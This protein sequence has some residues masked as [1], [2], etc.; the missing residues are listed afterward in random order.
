[1]T[2]IPQWTE[3]LALP[4]PEWVKVNKTKHGDQVNGVFMPSLKVKSLDVGQT[5]YYHFTFDEPFGW[6]IFTINN[7]TGEFSIQ[8]DWGNW[9]Y[10]WGIS[11][12]GEEAQAHE[13]PLA[14]F[15]SDRT[16]AGYIVNKFSY[17]R[18]DYEEFDGEETQEAIKKDIIRNRRDGE[19][20]A[21]EARMYWDKLD[22]IDF[23]DVNGFFQDME[24]NFTQDYIF[25]L[26]QEYIVMR[27]TAHFNILQYKLLPFFFEYLKREVI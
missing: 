20:D 8:S 17:N 12:L 14:Y 11:N 27:Q 16:E 13:K 18:K 24:Y 6:A 4:Y 9:S 23:D 5:D 26:P 25:G 15:L 3:D 21:E 7:K 22:R 2:E 1:M 19:I 10:R